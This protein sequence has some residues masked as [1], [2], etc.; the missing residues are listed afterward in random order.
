M[1]GSANNQLATDED[2][3]RIAD[4]GIIYVPD[5]VAN[6][7]GLIHVSAELDEFNAK[8]VKSRIS[9]IYDAVLSILSQAAADNLTPNEA[10]VRFAEDRIR[11]EG[12]GVTFRHGGQ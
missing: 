3:N 4:A 12:N 2:D 10:A 9:G 8:L 7:G 1:V 5:F 11:R 6:A